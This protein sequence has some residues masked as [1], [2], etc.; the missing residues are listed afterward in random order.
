MWTVAVIA[1]GVTVVAL[2]FSSFQAMVVSGELQRLMGRRRLKTRIGHL[3][4]HVVI[5]GYG[6]MGQLVA[7][8]LAGQGVHCVVIDVD[9]AR[10]AMVEEEGLFYVLGDAA[11]EAALIEAGLR[12]A[13]ALVATLPRPTPPTCMSR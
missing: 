9:P 2:A 11:E 12:R 6:R 4:G 10:T 5:C 1:G 13:R 3:S 8:G 7:D